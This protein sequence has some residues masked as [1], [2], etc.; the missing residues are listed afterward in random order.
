MARLPH[1]RSAGFTLI[2]VIVTLT[3]AAV[4]TVLAAPSFKNL[5][6]SQRL[7]TASFDLVTNLTLARSEAIKQNG[8]V[9]ITPVSTSNWADGWTVSGSGGT[10]RTQAAY[11]KIT[12]TGPT[13]L[14]YDRNGRTT[15]GAESSFQL[16]DSDS[17]STVQSRCV[18]VNLIGQPVSKLGSCS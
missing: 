3:I 6:T 13:T 8:N 9:T 18:K 12:I 4:L 15:T 16:S 10:I 1:Q 7:K 5:I 11:S 2:E 14:V 17:G